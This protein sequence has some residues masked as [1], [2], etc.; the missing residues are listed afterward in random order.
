MTITKSI[1][2]SDTLFLIDIELID[3]KGDSLFFVFSFSDRQF[4]EKFFVVGHTSAGFPHICNRVR[5]ETYVH[6]IERRCH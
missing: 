6:V 1:K 3:A 5:G 2:I 4:G